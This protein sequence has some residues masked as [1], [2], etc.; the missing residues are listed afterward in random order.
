MI[1][2]QAL[3]GADE[4]FHRVWREWRGMPEFKHEDLEAYDTVTCHFASEADL[5]AFEKF[6]DF[7]A[8]RERKRMNAVWYPKGA[9]GGYS[10]KRYVTRERVIP[11]YPLYIVSKGRAKTQLTSRALHEMGIPHHVVVESDQLD[12][13]QANAN[14]SA[15]YLVLDPTF[16]RDYDKLLPP[17]LAHQSPGSGPARNFA[18]AH[19]I[20]AGA[21][22]HWVMDDNLQQFNRLN[23]N[24]KTPVK[25]G[26]CFAAMEDFVERYTNVAMAGP[27]YFMFAVRKSDDTPPFYLNTRIYSCNLIRND[28]P[29]RWR[30]RYNEDT[31]LSLDLLK[32]GYCTILFNAFLQYKMGTQTMA[33]GNTTEL[34]GGG[35]LA[36]SQMLVDAH[37]DVARHAKRFHGAD[38]EKR[39]HHVVDYRPFW[40]ANHLE[41][42]PDVEIVD[43]TNNYGMRLERFDKTTKRWVP[44]A[45]DVPWYPWEDGR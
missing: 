23:R 19:S 14:A 36:K 37:P 26:A 40:R 24:L 9:I 17:E 4:D 31:I 1:E 10:D 39:D 21:R 16:Q 35:T 13:Y 33:G 22:R 15:T 32:A 45:G 8:R 11:R 29:F 44:M 6:I 34:Y 41:L 27:N 28:V 20:A 25:T 42:R 7:K 43:E 3:F 12:E 5:L 18:W 2:R 30:G 38:G